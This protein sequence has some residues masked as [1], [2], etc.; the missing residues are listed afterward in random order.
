MLRG[1]K[2]LLSISD[3][4]FPGTRINSV[5]ER[6]AIE[7]PEGSFKVRL[8][9]WKDGQIETQVELLRELKQ[10]ELATEPVDSSD[11]F[12]FHKTTRRPRW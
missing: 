7:N 2:I 3:F 4:T 5:L 6:I 8:T 9:L 12:L 11:R 10:V 1:L